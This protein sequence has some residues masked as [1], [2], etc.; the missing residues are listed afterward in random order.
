MLS[1]NPHPPIRGREKEAE[2]VRL[3]NWI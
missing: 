1:I 3:K 2:G